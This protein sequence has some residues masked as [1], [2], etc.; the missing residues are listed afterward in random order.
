MPVDL[1]LVSPERHLF[2]DETGCN[3]NQKTNGQVGHKRYVGDKGSK[4]TPLRQLR[5]S[6][7]LPFPTPIER[8][9]V[10]L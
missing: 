1:E 4:S 5:T 6:D 9:R 10:A 8:Y 2:R 3:T 7:S